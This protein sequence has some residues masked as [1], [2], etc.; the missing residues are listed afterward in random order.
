MKLI[1]GLE[2][3][4]SIRGFKPTP[5]SKETI[6]KILHA[7]SRSP[8]YTNSQPWEVAVVTGAKRDELS[9]ILYDLA[10]SGAKSNADVPAP[11]SWPEAIDSRTKVHGA[12]RF[13]ALGVGRDDTARRNE[14]RLQNFKFFDAPC[15]MFIFMDKSLGPWST[16]DMGI[17]IHG[18]TLAAHGLGLGTCLQASLANYPDA[19]RSAL[20]IPDNLQLV[21]G[22]SLGYPDHDA[23]LNKYKSTRVDV[24]SFT[25]WY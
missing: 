5:V 4:T 18:L 13:E 10:A 21:V 6:K 22:M 14:L 20:N 16:M 15:A 23:D 24:D 1:E 19:V 9:K 11:K 25:R 12:K 17:F 2:T 8:S 3:R 7:A